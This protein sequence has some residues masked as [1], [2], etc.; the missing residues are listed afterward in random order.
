[1]SAG[2]VQADERGGFPR[3]LATETA[4]GSDADILLAWLYGLTIFGFPL[5]STIPV[6]A[7]IESQLITVPYRALIVAL[8]L[9]IF[10]RWIMFGARIYAGALLA[11]LLAYWLLLLGRMMWD[12]FADPLPNPLLIP[13]WQLI[14][15]SL[16][17]CF[18]P[19]AALLQIPTVRTLVLVRRLTETLGFIALVLLLWLGVS[20]LTGNRVFHR[21]STDVLNPVSVGHLAVSV[22][23]CVAYSLAKGPPE[24]TRRSVRVLVTQFRSLVLLFALATAVASFSK[25]PLLCVILAGAFFCVMPVGRRGLGVGALATRVLLLALVAFGSVS[26]TF[27]LE[28]RGII[29]VVS[30]FDPTLGDQSSRERLQFFDGAWTQFLEHPVVGDRFVEVLSMSYPHNAVL[31]SMMSI[32]VLGLV[33]SLVANA[34][35]AFIAWRLVRSRGEAVWVG[36]IYFQYAIAQ[37]FSGSVILNSIY[38]AYFVACIAV[39]HM[40]AKRQKNLQQHTGAVAEAR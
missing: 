26:M 20:A 25:A 23:I 13:E 11:P 35:G 8:S 34:V 28:D 31:E 32:G 38:W 15:L 24:A 40:D 6:V 37:V 17:A 19:A 21:L 2:V 14:A 1:M 10:L 29:D 27:Y 30:R 4:R 36:L 22:F 3:D 39:F 7:S 9:A 16:G 33:L 18:I 12:I 5:A